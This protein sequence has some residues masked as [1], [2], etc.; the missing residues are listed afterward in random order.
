MRVR[1]TLERVVQAVARIPAVTIGIVLALAV[2]GG[3]LALRLTPNT[4]TDTFVNRSSPSYQASL[5]DERH[6]GGDPVV[7]LIREPLT[8]L[9]ETKDLGTV[10]ELEA[11]LAGQVLVPNQQLQA[12]T[13]APAG[14]Q[15]PYGGVNSPCGMLA[16]TRPAQVVYG[17]GTFLNRAVAAVNQQVLALEGGAQ[18]AVASARNS[19]YQLALAKHMTKKQAL[20]E[21]NAAGNL[22][23]QQEY[24]QLIQMYLNSGISGQ[25][26]IDDPQFIPEI[27]FDQ[28]RGVN[29]PKARFA[30][31]FPTKNSALIQVRL[32]A[33]LSASQQAQAISWIRQAVRMP[34]FRSA[35]GGTYT[36][37]GVPVVTD[38]LATTI[39]GSIA[40]LLAAALVVM[41][42]VLLLVFRSRLRLLPLVIA[43]A[44]VGITFGAVSLLGGS[45]TMASIAVLP[46]LIGLAVDYAVQFQ[47]RAQEGDGDVPRATVAAAP[48][49]AT[50]ALA[51]AAGFLALL[52]SPVPMVRGFGGLLIVG[53]AIALACA[54]SAGTAA[55]V[56]R[57]RAF[58]PRRLPDLG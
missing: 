35:Y 17:P 9:V 31:L 20:A 21:E 57:R 26:K 1:R 5:D 29:Q 44:A 39:T 46:I 16:K 40:G 55:M 41:A 12:F 50:A 6:F 8:D 47:A 11:C 18:K 32:K 52:L 49:I 27:V 45:L 51:T 30:Y 25:P 48:T 3:A 33:S 53:I 24:E 14:T 4:S 19:A 7:I 2:G 23:T 58:A 38:D 43:L 42:V 37:S 36:V 28:T 15:K 13:P 54:L 10:S 56:M 22:A 34:M